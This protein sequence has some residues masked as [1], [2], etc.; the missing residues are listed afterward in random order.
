MT[1]AMRHTL[2]TRSRQFELL[3]STLMQKSPRSHVLEQLSRLGALQQRLATAADKSVDARRHQLQLAARALD[4]V[5]P[6]ATLDR[7][8]AILTDA[9]S[10][11]ILSDA[12]KVAEGARI[13]A[14]LAIGSLE[15]TVNQTR[16]G[17]NENE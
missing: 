4:F 17:T 12:G 6:L 8:Y 11:R 5:S 9:A 13:R 10:G 1:G 15:A 16:N 3:R 14:R 2:S 7:G